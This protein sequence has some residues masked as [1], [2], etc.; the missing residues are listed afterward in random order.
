LRLCGEQKDFLGKPMIN[1][2]KK[3]PNIITILVFIILCSVLVAPAFAKEPKWRDV[4]KLLKQEDGTQIQGKY[5]YATGMAQTADGVRSDKAHEV[6]QKKSL[7]RAMQMVRMASSCKE[8]LDSLDREKRR[9][10]I[11]LFAPLAPPTHLEGVTVIRQR[12]KNAAHFTTVAIP[13]EAVKDLPCEFPDLLSAVSR[14]ANF[15]HISITGLAFCL[16]HTPRYSHLNRS[17]L[18]LTGQL[19]Q[20]RGSI[21]LAR[22]FLRNQDTNVGNSPLKTLSLQNRLA[23]AMELTLQAEQLSEQ[24]K[25]KEALEHISRALDLA[26][27]FSRSYLP[28]ADFFLEEQKNPVFSL[29]AAQKALRDGTCFKAALKRVILCLEELDSP[30][31]EVFQFLLSQCQQDGSNPFPDSWKADLELLDDTNVPYLVMLSLGQA[32]EGP[33]QPPGPKF[34]RTAK[35]FNQ[36]KNDDDV[37][38]V[39]SLLLQA[40]EKQP[41]SAETHNLIGACYRHLGQ[42]VMALPFLWQALTLEPEYDYAL[43]NL[44]LCCQKLGLM[45]SAGFYFEQQAVKNSPSNWVQGCYTKFCEPDK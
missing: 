31:K 27:G 3:I 14:Y 5:L 29:C 38:K 45:K 25:W 8:L 26:P 16:G 43:A 4:P 33:S 22:C 37:I 1:S 30:E 12:E 42:P 32:V 18:E 2:K 41:A 19:Y 24:R 21:V 7:L 9:Q 20:K 6:A 10:F 17:L 11:R 34:G 39:L 15:D 40:C 13:L 28:L 35:L 36:A 23:R 44:G